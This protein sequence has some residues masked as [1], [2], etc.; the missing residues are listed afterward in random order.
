[1]NWTPNCT[2]PMT[3]LELFSGVP[4]QVKVFARIQIAVGWRFFVVDQVRG[5]CYYDKGTITIPIW[6][7]RSKRIGQKIWY[8][9]HELAHTFEPG[10]SHGQRFMRKLREICPIEHQHYEIGYKPRNAIAA[11]IRIPLDSI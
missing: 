1:M 10:D 9:S 3:N 5:K 7:I 4:E 11:G 6:V 2:I 8:I